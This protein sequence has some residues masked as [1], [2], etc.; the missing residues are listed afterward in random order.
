MIYNGYQKLKKGDL[1]K[2]PKSV[3]YY[4]W[5]E[6]PLCTR[7]A[8]DKYFHENETSVEEMTNRICS[9]FS[10]KKLKEEMQRMILTGT[11]FPGGRSLYGAGAKGKFKATMSNCYIMN[12]LGEDSLE[13]IFDSCK[14]ISTILKGGGGIG[15]AISG[16]RPNGAKTNN[17]ARSSTGAVSFL[18][19]YNATGA[20][21]GYHGRR[22]AMLVGLDI[23]HPD[24]EEFID[25]RSK[26]D[27]KSMNISCVIDD[28]FMKAVIKGKKYELHFDVKATGEKIRKKV[29][30]RKLYDKL[31]Y[32]NW[33]YGDP[34][35]LFKGAVDH[36]NLQEKCEKFKI[37]ICNPCAEYTGPAYNSCN[38][39]SINL[40]NFVRNKFTT[41]A[42]FDYVNFGKAIDVAIEALDEIL[43]Y[44][45]D[46]Q[47]LDQNREIIDK[48][49]SIGLGFFGLADVFVA[50]RMAY[51]SPQS[52]KLADEISYF[53][54]KRAILASSALA[55]AKGSYNEFDAKAVC[56]CSMIAAMK[57]EDRDEIKKAIKTQG[58][59]NAQLISIAPTGSLSI[60]A[61]SVSSG[62]EPIYK[63]VYE[64]SSHSLED[65]GIHFTLADRAIA[66]LLK[67]N[68][69]ENLSSKEIKEQFPWVVEAD[70]ID[71]MNR[72]RMQ[73]ALQKNID[74]AISSTI[75]LP[76]EATVDQIKNIYMMA[77]DMG[78]KGVTVFRNN[79]KRA[80]ILG[81]SKK[82]P[83]IEFTKETMMVPKMQN[84][85]LV[86]TEPK[87]KE[88]AERTYDFISANTEMI[89]DPKIQT[90]SGSKTTLGFECLK[91][92]PK[93]LANQKEFENQVAE[94][95]GEDKKHSYEQTELDF[96]KPTEEEIK[97][98]SL[99]PISRKKKTGALSGR[100]YRK[101]TACV[102]ALYVTVNRD[103]NGN[104]FE[105]FTNKANH[106]CSANIASITRLVS[107]SLRSGIAVQDIIAELKENS[108]QACIQVM[109]EHPEYGLSLSCPYAIAEAIEEEYKHINKEHK[110]VKA[111][112]FEMNAGKQSES[113]Q[114]EEKFVEELH[115]DSGAAMKCPECGNET[116]IPEGKCVSCKMCGYSKCD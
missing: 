112:K 85:K 9:I 47:P 97:L 16:L 99:H 53:M 10:K 81:F 63:C 54:M 75:N 41:K 8:H 15:I 114:E 29:D 106:G 13:C 12:D 14:E 59:R 87:N 84:G 88:E 36:H 76:E 116:L 43:D 6:D 40:Y 92:V 57:K 109:K 80:S 77:W 33:D 1:K 11:F 90:G 93:K 27:L 68:H 55:K 110:E 69:L 37:F 38:L 23:W 64:R 52:I 39:G 108:C 66:D 67:K 70:D 61:G 100:T 31:C 115:K 65:S 104:I 91:P 45:Y 62:I 56:D 7:V 44:G 71:P 49:R 26:K 94:L 30:A 74:N 2:L 50:M 21:I 105:V 86:F 3:T 22:G 83:D 5:W 101:R 48:W 19:I 96:S 32:M 35:M 4:K 20:V 78:L 95:W 113:I 18:D 89:K 34:G 111:D 98:D 73:A 42:H 51:G 72:V 79:C 25:I 24:I 102:R 82:R 17:S 60:L 58:L 103:E 107:L 28:E 46:T